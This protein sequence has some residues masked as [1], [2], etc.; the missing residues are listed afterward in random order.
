VQQFEAVGLLES[1]QKDFVHTRGDEH[2]TKGRA[3]SAT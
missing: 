2:D 3:V 1:E